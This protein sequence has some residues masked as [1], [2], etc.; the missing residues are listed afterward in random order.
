MAFRDRQIWVETLL[1]LSN[2]RIIRLLWTS[3]VTELDFR[4]FIHTNG[5]KHT[6]ET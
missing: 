5:E 3:Y 1:A 4:I 6:C 2:T